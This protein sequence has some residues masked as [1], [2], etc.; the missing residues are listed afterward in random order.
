MKINVGQTNVFFMS[1]PHYDHKSLVRG[2]S[3]WEDKSPCRPFD[4]LEEHNNALVENINAKVGRRDILFCLGDW[5]FGSLSKEREEKAREFRSRLICRNVILILGNHDQTIRDNENGIQN[6]FQGVYNYL[7][8]EFIIPYKGKEQGV[9][10]KKQKA[11]L[12]H[13]PIRSWNWMR[14]GS[15]MLHGHCHNTLPDLVVKGNTQRTMDVGVDTNKE[16]A[17]YNFYEIL[18][19]MENRQVLTEDHH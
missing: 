12:M 4:T 6:I 3:N 18:D 5:S 7:E 1:D 17:P 10:A 2:V 13:Y 15:W 19:I 11:C 8:V 16:L 9:K 14:K